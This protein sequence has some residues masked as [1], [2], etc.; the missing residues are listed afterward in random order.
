M[1]FSERTRQAEQIVS[2][3][4]WQVLLDEAEKQQPWLGPSYYVA[5]GFH[6]S[7]ATL[8]SLLPAFWLAELTN[9]IFALAFVSIGIILDIQA[10]QDRRT[11]FQ[12]STWRQL[13]GAPK[14]ETSRF[15]KGISILL[16]LFSGVVFVCI[17]MGARKWIDPAVA[18]YLLIILHMMF[19]LSINHI[20]NWINYSVGRGDFRA[21]KG[22]AREPYATELLFDPSSRMIYGAMLL[23]F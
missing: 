12:P 19:A 13:L 20:K 10:F 8:A 3:P 14:V 6:Y 22:L 2:S 21:F 4:Q 7:A 5:I 9:I 18:I 23:V 1:N 15:E 17:F 11:L 16:L